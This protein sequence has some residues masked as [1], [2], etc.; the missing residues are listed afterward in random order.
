M[1]SKLKVLIVDDDPHMVKTISDILKMEGHE[2]YS[3]YSGEEGVEEV[4]EVIPDCVL[5]DIKM[6]GIDGIKSMVMMKEFFP[7]LPVVLMSAYSTEEE[8]KEAKLQGACSVLTKPIDI[9]LLLAFLTLLRREKN[10]LIVDNDILSSSRLKDLLL[11]RDYQADTEV[12]PDKVLNIME[13][14]YELAVLLDLNVGDADGLEIL[15]DIRSRYPTKP[16]VLTAG[17]SEETDRAI[18]TGLKIGAY[19]CL[20]KP[21]DTRTLLRT[22]EGIRYEKLSSFLEGAHLSRG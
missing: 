16:V 21:F 10:I 8:S 19:S 14:K 15:R 18:K 17:Y 20:Y 12:N 3:T 13:K 7:H 22:I 6:P 9:R 1:D 2:P 11:S 4:K 5:M